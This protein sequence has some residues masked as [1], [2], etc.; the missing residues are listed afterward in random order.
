MNLK[1]VLFDLGGT[2]LWFRNDTN[3]LYASRV[4]LHRFLSKKGF[5]VTT[6]EV[7]SISK[8]VWD[9]YTAFANATL[10]E[11]SFTQLMKAILY[12][13][14]IDEN[15]H[16][17]LVD[18][19]V[20]AFYNPLI[21][22]SYLLDGARDLLLHLQDRGLKLGLVTDNESQYFHMQLLEKHS[23]AQFFQS[24]S[25]SYALGLRKPHHMMF[26]QCLHDL[27]V[28]PAEALFIGDRL[29]HD[30]YGAQNAGLSSIWITREKIAQVT[31]QP[32]W[33]VNSLTEVEIIIDKLS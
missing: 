12:R 6:D 16:M 28:E 5:D 26:L 8:N 17:E 3:L 13:L 18:D 32:N 10:I 11:L 23:L 31:I 14:H 30:I 33:T 2:L 9:S 15:T 24:I 7:I 22:Q 27:Y 29:I 25:V 19:A 4:A 20:E 1:A 21:E